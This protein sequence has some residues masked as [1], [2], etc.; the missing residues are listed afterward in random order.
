MLIHKDNDEV[1]GIDFG[2]ATS[3]AGVFDN[4][5][6]RIFQNE[7][8]NSNTPSFTSIVG[9]EIWN[10]E[11]A[12]QQMIPNPHNTFY[13]IK[14]LI[15]FNNDDNITEYPFTIVKT[16]DTLN[17]KQ[18][19]SDK[20][21]AIDYIASVILNG[22]REMAQNSL[23]IE[24]NRAVIAVPAYFNENQTKLIREAGSK[25]GFRAIKIVKEP[26]AAA[27]A[28]GLNKN[29]TKKQ[30]I[31]V[32]HLGGF[33]N[34]VTLLEIENSFIK[35]L[36]SQVD[37]D[38][39]GDNF[40]KRIVDY[41][42]QHLENESYKINYNDYNFIQKLKLE[43]ER[44]KKILSVHPKKVQ[45]INTM[46]TAKVNELKELRKNY[47]NQIRWFIVQMWWGDKVIYERDL[48]LRKVL[49]NH[50]NN[51]FPEIYQIYTKHQWEERERLEIEN[52]D[53]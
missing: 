6:V 12:K 32:F 52:Q 16:N 44:A 40:N 39:C 4:S 20:T 41:L 35:V 49:L 36:D 30:K 3:C 9:N 2:S 23:K 50:F 38:A 48:E 51:I 14:K 8:G 19:N 43:V 45:E 42:L 25:A 53:F 31:I 22:M 21:F 17:I 27:I 37:N 7:H 33:T 13:A 47:I 11:R 26:N 28:Y 5:K 18:Y 34:D 1:I 29:Q 10:G 46:Y 15:G 24:V